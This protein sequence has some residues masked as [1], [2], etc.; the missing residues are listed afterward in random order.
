MENNQKS[1]HATCPYYKRCRTCEVTLYI[2]GMSI[3]IAFILG[4]AFYVFKNN[5]LW[6]QDFKNCIKNIDTEKEIKY[7]HLVQQAYERQFN[8]LLYLMV[9]LASLIAIGVPI[10]THLGTTSHLKRYLDDIKV[11]HDKDL[12]SLQDELS[13][14]IE[15]L[16]NAEEKELQAFMRGENSELT[17]QIRE[18]IQGEINKKISKF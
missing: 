9:G 2:I 6:N 15:K 7:H 1:N 5:K 13:D 10:V 12:K 14:E 18:I 4:I 8:D 11:E 3:L 17:K 16:K